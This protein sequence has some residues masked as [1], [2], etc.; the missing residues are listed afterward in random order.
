MYKFEVFH[1]KRLRKE[2]RIKWRIEVVSEL[3]FCKAAQLIQL[4]MIFENKV[5]YVYLPQLLPVLKRQGH[6]LNLELTNWPDC[7]VNCGDPAVCFPGA[8]ITGMLCNTWLFTWIL[9]IRTQVLKLTEQALYRLS[10]LLTP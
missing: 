1:N 3:L 8:E 6:S 9:E 4:K 10:Y 2:S 7:P 5:M